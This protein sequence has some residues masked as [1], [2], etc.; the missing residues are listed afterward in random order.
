MCI[1]FIAVE[2]HPQYPLILAANRDEFHS[3]PSH[4]AHFWGDAPQVLAGRDLQAGG[5]WF[6][7]SKTGQIAAVTNLRL[8]ELI[9]ADARSRG[10][11]VARYLRGDEPPEQFR[12]FV[13]NKF[14]E[15]NPFNLLFGDTAQ[16]Y[17]FSSLTPVFKPLTPGFHSISNGTPDDYW[18]KMSRGVNLLKRCIL[19]SGE[20]DVEQLAAVMR[21]ETQAADSALPATGISRADEKWLSSIFI[22]GDQYGTRATSLLLCQPQR[23]RLVEYNYRADGSLADTQSFT[24]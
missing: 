15:F 16:L 19:Q 17:V 22:S 23:I 4:A 8:P 7:V 24:I 18:P 11:L 10:E 2:Q 13:A 14:C 5:T 21:D 6:G 9:R 20:L 1:L 3:R 12:D